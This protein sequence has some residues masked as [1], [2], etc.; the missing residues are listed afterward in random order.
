MDEREKDVVLFESES[1]ETAEIKIVKLSECAMSNIGIRNLEL[2]GGSIAPT[3]E[4]EHKI[5]F[6]GDSITCGYGVD[7]ED[8][9]H[10]FSTATE[11]CTKAYAYKTAEKLDADYSLVSISGYGIISGY[12]A[13]PENIVDNQTIPPYY[14]TLGFCYNTFANGERP[15][16]IA[17]DFAKFT[18]D[19]IVINLGTND[20]SYCNTQEKMDTFA[21][22][23]T[24]FLK[25]IRENN[26]DAKI[27]CTLGIMGANLYPSIEYAVYNYTEETGDDNIVSYSLKIS[28]RPTVLQLIITPPRLLMKKLPTCWLKLSTLRWAGLNLN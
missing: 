13:N 21:A 24:E 4:K 7:D 22:A 10:S 26:P 8:P 11:D 3:E 25:T 27:F 15:S 16:D 20:A 19:C 14:E 1:E 12:T 23:Y 9:T 6:I 2:N 5:E 17:W 18:P 28:S